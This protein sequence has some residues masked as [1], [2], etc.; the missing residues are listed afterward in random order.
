MIN[1]QE[2]SLGGEKTTKRIILKNNELIV[3]IITYGAHLYRILTKD[4][5]DEWDN[6]ILNVTPIEAML[7][8]SCHFG[9]IVGP[10]AGRIAQ[11]K[12]G[13]LQVAQ[14]ENGHCLHSGSNGWSWQEW[15]VQSTYEKEDESGVILALCDTSSGFANEIQTECQIYIKQ[16]ELGLI[17]RAKSNELTAFNP[18]NHAYFNLAGIKK[19]Q[20]I[21]NH[22]LMVQANEVLALDATLIPTGEKMNVEKTGYDFRLPRMI[23]D[24]LAQLKTGLDVPFVLRETQPQLILEDKTSGRRMEISSDRKT[25][26]LYS[27]SNFS[28]KIEVSNQLMQSEFGLAIEFQEAPNIQPE[29]ENWSDI[30]LESN[31]WKEKKVQ[32][33]FFADQLI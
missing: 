23:G 16:N 27:A 5:M 13:D 2:I 1:I 19:L 21:K 22:T 30:E 8:D 32:Y 25:V 6:I 14:N 9:S 15:S 11:G 26:V 28:K 31:E 4:R 12:I 33:R 3:E 20:S 17:F 10:V 18:T 7:T 24:A 29:D